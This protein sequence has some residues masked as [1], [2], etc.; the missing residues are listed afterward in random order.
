MKI[1]IVFIAIAALA[2]AC[3]DQGSKVEETAGI[4]KKAQEDTLY[5]A[6]MEGH[7]VGMAKMGKLKRSMS[8][9]QQKLDS[10]A[11]LSVAKIDTVY[12][13]N[14]LSVQKALT[15]AE[16][17]MNNWMDNFKLDSAKD[18][19]DLRIKYLEGEKATVTVVRDKILNSIQLAD[20]ILAK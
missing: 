8:Q 17:H 12:R 18:N 6:V 7:D 4:D 20:S 10:L 2:I 14:L 5:H 3:S 9:V 15:D 16:G 1:S 13:N 19:P 11:K